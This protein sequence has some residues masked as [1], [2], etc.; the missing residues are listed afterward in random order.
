MSKIILSRE[1][2]VCGVVQNIYGEKMVCLKQFEIFTM[3]V[4]VVGKGIKLV[5]K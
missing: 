1:D 2:T 5:A 3:S 4:R